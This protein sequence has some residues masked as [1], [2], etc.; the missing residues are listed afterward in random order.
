MQLVSNLTATDGGIDFG[1]AANLTFSGV[2][3]LSTDYKFEA[4]SCGAGSPR[5]QIN[6]DTGSGEKNIFVY[7]GPPP[8]FTGCPANVWTS[9][10]DLVNTG[11]VD[12]S[13]LPGGSFYDTWAHAQANYGSYPVT[14]IQLVADARYAFPSTGQTVDIDNTTINSTLY[15]Y[16]F[17]SKDDCKN[18][19]WQ[20]NFIYP[21]GP[22]KNQGDCVSYFAKRQH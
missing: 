7:I 10:G 9:S 20:T 15:D 12:T 3:H 2:Q 16:E 17:T 6:V 4:G 5:F 22:F 18:G 21:P 11:T 13:Q 19:G 1:V 14:G 8:N